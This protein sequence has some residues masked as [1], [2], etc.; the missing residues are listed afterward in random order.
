MLVAPG[1]LKCPGL[2]RMLGLSV[3]GVV[4]AILVD[5]NI[6]LTLGDIVLCVMMQFKR[7][8]RCRR[9]KDNKKRKATPILLDSSAQEMTR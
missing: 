7:R 8:S 2:L 1:P 3:F 4:L 6:K 9:D 5:W